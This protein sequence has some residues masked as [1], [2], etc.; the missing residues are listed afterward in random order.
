[1]SEDG[2]KKHSLV[3][4]VTGPINMAVVGAAAIG[5][6]ALHSWP[7]VALGGVAYAA[8]VAWDF[9]SGSEKKKGSRAE[10]TTLPDPGKL[11]DQATRSA[12]LTIRGAQ[13]ELARVL[14]ET[15]ED[16]KANLALAL[17]SADELV[18]RAAVLARRSEDLGKYLSM[19]DPR[20]L[21]A[22]VA[23][24]RQRVASTEDPEAK[25]QYDTARKAREEHLGVILE[26]GKTKERVSASLLGIAATLE[27]LP[28]KVVR[29]RALDEHA[30]D[31][32][33]GSVKDELD[34][35]NG[36]MKS[37]ED[38]LASIAEAVKK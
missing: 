30:M 25:A 4:A 20:V 6:V 21:E 22:D 33:S 9:V 24:L 34:R 36:E 15:S 8:L 3:K 18:E 2:A 17:I 29:M 38:T 5:A 11:K 32:A 16:V 1:M 37:L 12:V 31:E 13:A 28:A 7:V 10:R 14:H 26:L 19:I 35:M 27:G 23:Q